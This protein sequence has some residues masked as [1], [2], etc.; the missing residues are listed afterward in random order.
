MRDTR[1][2]NNHFLKLDE[3]GD[4]YAF[5]TTKRVCRDNTYFFF[6]FAHVSRKQFDDYEIIVIEV[7]LAI[8][9]NGGQVQA[10]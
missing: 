1:G 7:D 10:A 2:R 6:F 8:I 9:T 4:M 5:P 3:H